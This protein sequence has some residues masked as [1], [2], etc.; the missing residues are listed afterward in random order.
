MKVYQEAKQN[1]TKKIPGNYYSQYFKDVCK[2][3]KAELEKT[4]EKVSAVDCAKVAGKR[5]K[6]MDESSKQKY[7]DEYEKKMVAYRQAKENQDTQP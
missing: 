3:I 4:M 7:K 1:M 2:D 6:E 5:W